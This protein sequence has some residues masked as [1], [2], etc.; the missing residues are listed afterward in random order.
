[1]NKM[2]H[3][4]ILLLSAVCGFAIIAGTSGI[5]LFE[6]FKYLCY[7][8]CMFYSGLGYLSCSGKGVWK[9]S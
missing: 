4:F 8:F 9:F 7:C 1:M 2:I 6:S 3:N 5:N